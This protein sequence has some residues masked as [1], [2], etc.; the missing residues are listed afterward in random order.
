[1]DQGKVKERDEEACA[2]EKKV[3]AAVAAEDEEG[4]DGPED[5]DEVG[6]V[7]ACGEGKGTVGEKDVVVQKE[8]HELEGIVDVVDEDQ[9]VAAVEY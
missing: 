4:E 9:I 7:V 8:G 2:E 6:V 1:M 5:E 3:E